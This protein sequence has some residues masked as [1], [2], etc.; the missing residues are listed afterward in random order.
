MAYGIPGTGCCSTT[1]DIIPY[2]LVVPA[3]ASKKGVVLRLDSVGFPSNLPLFVCRLLVLRGAI[4]NR[5]CG[6]GGVVSTQDL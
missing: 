5:T 3:A 6:T 4:V 2:I 1:Y